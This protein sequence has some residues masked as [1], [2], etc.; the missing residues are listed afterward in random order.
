MNSKLRNAFTG[1]LTI[2]A[3]GYISNRVFE[4]NSVV[5]NTIFFAALVIGLFGTSLF[6]WM[7]HRTKSK[8]KGRR[9]V[10][11]AST[12]YFVFIVIICIWAVLEKLGILP[13]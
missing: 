8:G 10:S 6:R 2:G 1:I 4:I 9:A 7:E 5:A 13:Y 3:F 12:A 11:I